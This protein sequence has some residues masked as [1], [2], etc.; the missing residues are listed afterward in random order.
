VTKV[1]DDEVEVEI[2]SGVKVR[3]IKSTITAVVTAT[4][5]RAND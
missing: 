2:A 1:A 4:P 3:V 5:A